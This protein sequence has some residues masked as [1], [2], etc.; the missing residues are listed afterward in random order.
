VVP[1]LLGRAILPG[2]FLIV[3]RG[4]SLFGWHGRGFLCG[5]GVSVPP[6]PVPRV[7]VVAPVAIVPALALL[8]AGARS[9]LWIG[10]GLA[11]GR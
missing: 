7:L 3:V 5:T 9:S 4:F 2:L 6:G 1:V 10:C 8:L 11:D